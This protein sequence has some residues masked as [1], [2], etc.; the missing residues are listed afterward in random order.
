MISIDRWRSTA[1]CS[2]TIRVPHSRHPYGNKNMIYQS[3]DQFNA[4]I[5]PVTSLKHHIDV[6]PFPGERCYNQPRALIA[7]R[8]IEAGIIKRAQ[9]RWNDKGGGWLEGVRGGS[10]TTWLNLPEK[11]LSLLISA[12]VLTVTLPTTTPTPTHLATHPPVWSL[13]KQNLNIWLRAANCANNGIISPLSRR[14]VAVQPLG[15]AYRAP[16]STAGIIYCQLAKV[17]VYKQN[18]RATFTSITLF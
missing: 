2:H 17:R 10:H 15:L 13:S 14:P 1:S 5:I 9:E 16:M 12:A 8:E 11:R 18:V 7:R 4:R 6:N 3:G